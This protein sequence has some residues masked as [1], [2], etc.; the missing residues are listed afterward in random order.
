MD[1]GAWSW[2]PEAIVPLLLAAGYL[3]VARRE[4]SAARLVSFVAGCALLAVAL[5]SPLDTVARDYLVWGHLLQ[6][7]VLAEWAPLLL[8]LGIP[9]GLAERLVRPAAV[10][11]LT[12]PVVALPLWIATY[13]VWHVPALYD[14]ALASRR[15]TTRY[16]AA[17]R[18]GT[19]ASGLHDHA[20]GSTTLRYFGAGVAQLVER[21]PSKLN[22]AG[23]SP[24][25]RFGL[26]IARAVA[27]T[28]PSLRGA[29]PSAATPGRAA[30][31]GVR[32][33]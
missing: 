16:P 20:P 14:A 23:S 33:D 22:V 3:V 18:S 5:A 2:S 28:A 29:R 12:R 25:A 8:V 11:S 9:P 32:M 26:S 21:Q 15:A 27:G 31:R 10:R 4:A 1:P 17:S 19:I 6:N 7:V 13:A 24:V 30:C